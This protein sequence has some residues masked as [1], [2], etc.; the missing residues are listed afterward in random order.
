MKKPVFR[1]RP[2]DR[3]QAKI[4]NFLRDR[5]WHVEKMHGNAFQKGIPDL[6]CFNPLLGGEEGLHRWVDVKVEGQYEYTKSQCQKWP[7][8]ESIGLG[9]WIMMGPTEEWYKK[10]F[11]PPNF[12][13]Y[14]KPRYDK[15]LESPEKIMSELFEEST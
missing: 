7:L 12:R 2:E 4:I 9:V 8:W 10:L 1:S 13:D 6:Y 11:G 5:K 15:Y 3:I 14:W